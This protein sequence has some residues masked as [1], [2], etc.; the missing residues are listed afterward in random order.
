MEQKK[1]LKMMETYAEIVRATGSQSHTNQGNAY[2]WD[3]TIDKVSF[4]R[5]ELFGKK[6]KPVIRIS[7]MA[8]ANGSD[9]L[10]F[11]K[12]YQIIGYANYHRITCKHP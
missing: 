10:D 11:D 9:E 8:E 7:E 1:S 5:I 6:G 12:I 3:F 2:Y 4:I